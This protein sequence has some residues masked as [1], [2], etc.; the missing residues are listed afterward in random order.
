MSKHSTSSARRPRSHR[1]AAP[2]A[3][4]GAVKPPCSARDLARRVFSQHDMVEIAG[5]L[6][7]GDAPKGASVKAR[8]WEKLIE[9]AFG[10]QRTEPAPLKDPV[11]VIWDLPCPE[12]EKRPPE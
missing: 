8:V 10:K 12:R 1:A 5:E 3:Q 4:P 11:E 2:A 6:L 9:L 7:R